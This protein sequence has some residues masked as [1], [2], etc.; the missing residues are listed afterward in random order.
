M[1]KLLTSVQ[2]FELPNPKFSARGG[3]R[4]HE[5]LRYQILSLAPLTWL[6]DPRIYDDTFLPFCLFDYII[7]KILILN[8]VLIIL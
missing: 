5:N 8:N 2:K 1:H 4:T 3:I 6:G 7:L